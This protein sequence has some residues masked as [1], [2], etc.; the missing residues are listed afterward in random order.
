MSSFYA[1]IIDE[2]WL[3]FGNGVTEKFTFRGLG[4][5]GPFD[6]HQLSRKE[7]LNVLFIYPEGKKDISDYMFDKLVSGYRNFNGFNRLFRQD[8]QKINGLE[9]P[10]KSIS[11]GAVI[12]NEYKTKLKNFLQNQ[13]NEIDTAIIMHPGKPYFTYESPYFSTKILLAAHGKPTQSIDIEKFENLIGNDSLKYYLANVSLAIYA[14][15]GGKPWALDIGPGG[16]DLILGV[17]GTRVDTQNYFA[18]TT[19]FERNGTFDYWASDISR[20]EE[21]YV[22]LL[23][24]QISIVI[25]DY[26][27]EH[28]ETQVKKVSF[29]IAGKRPGKLEKQAVLE[30]MKERGA[31]F[32]YALFHINTSS[33]FWIMDD[34]NNFFL[35]NEGLKVSLTSKDFLIIV[36]GYRPAVKSIRRLV[37]PLRITA[38]DFTVPYE[39]IHNMVKEIYWLTRMNWKGFRAKKIPVSVY[40]PRILAYLLYNL[41]MHDREGVFNDIMLETTLRKKAWFL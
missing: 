19:L 36:E 12:A 14:K 37:K 32:E 41:R 5:G 18:F 1:E 25:D 33:L 30:V 13:R 21:G 2:P 38:I 29:H 11:Q 16:S 40:Y 39:E 27:K 26:I 4:R 6:I 15:T 22:K 3:R 35:P 31:E 8:L 24:S 23:K 28:P 9:I 17:G 20:G 10:I 34:K 7:K